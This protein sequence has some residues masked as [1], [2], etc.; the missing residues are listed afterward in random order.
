L[1]EELVLE[2]ALT[3]PLAVDFF[4]IFGALGK[5]GGQGTKR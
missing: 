3:M 5:I 4:F 2:N 1:K